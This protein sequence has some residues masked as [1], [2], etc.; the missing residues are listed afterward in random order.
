MATMTL[1]EAQVKRELDIDGNRAQGVVDYSTGDALSD[2]VFEVVEGRKFMSNGKGGQHS[3]GPGHR[4]RPTVRQ[5]E[6]TERGKGG[7]V[8]KARELSGTEMDALGR[9]PR[10]RGAD[11]GLRQFKMAPSTL[12]YAIEN[13]LTEDEFRATEPEGSDGRYTLAQAEAMAEARGV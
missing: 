4:F 12:Q 8:G 10:S 7:L 9:R 6:Q 1:K 13:G 2:R 11:I 3:L 5:V